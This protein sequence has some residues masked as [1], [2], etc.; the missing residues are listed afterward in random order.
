MPGA[1]KNGIV[2]RK[3]SETLQ[4]ELPGLRCRFELLIHC[5]LVERALHQK[6]D[7]REVLL[8]KMRIG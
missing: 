2:L 7:S 4:Y 8:P 3:S 5:N 1:R 6:E